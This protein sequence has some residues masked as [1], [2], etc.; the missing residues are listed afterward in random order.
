M[1]LICQGL[2]DRTLL[3]MRSVGQCDISDK[4]LLF[5]LK[6]LP[7][8]LPTLCQKAEKVDQATILPKMPFSET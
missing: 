8:T 4:L 7:K 3:P 6:S 2:K 5:Y 1:L